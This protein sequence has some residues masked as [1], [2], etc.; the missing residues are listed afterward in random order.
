MD[1]YADPCLDAPCQNGGQCL[2]P[3]YATP[4]EC[5]CLPAYGGA[6]CEQGRCSD[7]ASPGQYPCDA[8]DP[9]A[10]CV[11]DAAT[12]PLGAGERPQGLCDAA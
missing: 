5:Q 6:F 2:P 10:V 1:V 4:Y 12:G 3:T 11:P 8:A 9:D 7:P